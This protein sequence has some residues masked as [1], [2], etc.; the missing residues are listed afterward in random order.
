MTVKQRISLAVAMLLL[1]VLV[2]GIVWYM[3]RPEP[4]PE[5]LFVQKNES[6]PVTCFLCGG[7][8]WR[9]S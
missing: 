3:K 5:G 2:I 7:E 8:E 1:L 9:S 4:D 6:E